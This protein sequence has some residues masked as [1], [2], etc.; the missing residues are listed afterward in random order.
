MS[1]FQKFTV[2]IFFLFTF[3]TNYIYAAV[4]LK[5]SFLPSVAFVNRSDIVFTSHNTLLFGTGQMW[6]G[7]YFGHE[8]ISENV[9]DQTIGGALR[10][11]QQTFFEIQGGAYTR[12]FTQYQTDLKG[13]GFAAQLIYGT[14]LNNYFGLSAALS[15]KR[16]TSGMEKRT[17]ITLL[18]L[19]TL[20]W[21]F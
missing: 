18:P 13:K 8:I 9:T 21:G 11:G 15:G 4:E 7:G 10:F 16:I 3:F 6:V 2:L 1:V 5:S 19:L 12:K 20:R 14:H 17:I